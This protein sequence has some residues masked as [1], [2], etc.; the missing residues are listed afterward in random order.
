[1]LV[2]KIV[3]CS[4]CKKTHDAG[5]EH[6]CG[7]AKKLKKYTAV[8]RRVVVE[9]YDVSCEAYSEEEFRNMVLTNQWY[10][11]KHTNKK[12]DEI[13]IGSVLKPEE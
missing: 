8:V 6:V 11:E 12:I 5:E 13:K 2:G 7:D 4:Q 10:L 9:E 3:I 1:M